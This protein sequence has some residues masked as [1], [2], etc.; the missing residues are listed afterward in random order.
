MNF[1][2]HLLDPFQLIHYNIVSA[3]HDVILSKVLYMF[4]NKKDDELIDGIIS[5]K[6]H[7]IKCK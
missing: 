3:L 5:V 7:I 2:T 1:I 4:I 6:W